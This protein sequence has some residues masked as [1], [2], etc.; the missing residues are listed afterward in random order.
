MSGEPDRQY[1][2]ARSVLLDAL[3]ALGAQRPAVILVGAQAIYM[4]TSAIDLAVA[5][6]TTDADITLDPA[7]L[8]ASPKIESAMTAAGFR[9]GNRVGAWVVSPTSTACPP[10]SKSI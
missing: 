7:L 3:E 6:F 2:V 4:H 8:Q 9:R 1:T 5:E 10:T